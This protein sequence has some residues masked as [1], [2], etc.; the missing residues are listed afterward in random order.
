MRYVLVCKVYIII[1]TFIGRQPKIKD[2][3]RWCVSHMA[4]VRE[5]KP[6]RP[7]LFTNSSQSL[8]KNVFFYFCKRANQQQ[9][10]N[11]RSCFVCVCTT[12]V[13]MSGVLRGNYK[14]HN[15]VWEVELYLI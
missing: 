11:G 14:S 13:K 9:A 10:W 4:Y 12:G 2:V 3:T 15:H 5:G 7:S 1:Y 6:T 8:H